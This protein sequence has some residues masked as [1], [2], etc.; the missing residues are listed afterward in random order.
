ME[1]KL[2]HV[3]MEVLAKGDAS[4]VV[5]LVGYRMPLLLL[6]PDAVAELKRTTEAAA[7]RAQAG[8]GNLADAVQDFLRCLSALT[9]QFETEAMRFGDYINDRGKENAEA[10]TQELEAEMLVVK[11]LG[12]NSAGAGT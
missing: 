2:P 6:H 1:A 12:S 11:Q 5:R 9:A 3:A 10:A 4:T 8:G 7:L